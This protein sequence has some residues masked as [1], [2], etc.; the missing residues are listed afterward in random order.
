MNKKSVLRKGIEYAIY[1]S[2]LVALYFVLS[3]I[4]AFLLI[5]PDDIG[6]E[7]IMSGVTTGEPSPYCWFIRYPL[8]YVIS[9]LYKLVGSVEWYE[10]FLMGCHVLCYYLVLCRAI[11]LDRKDKVKYVTIALG[12]V[13]V[14]FGEHII[15]LEWSITAG[16]MGAVAVYRY[17][18]IPLDIKK[19][20]ATFEYFICLCLLVVGFSLRHNVIYMYMPLAFLCW[21]KRMYDIKNTVS[22]NK[23][24]RKHMGLNLAFIVTAICCIVV[25]MFIHSK[26]YSTKEWETYREYT[27]DRSILVDYYGYPAYDEYE[28]LYE[29]AG[30][31]KEMYYIMTRD[32]NYF[33]A[34]DNVDKIQLD[35]IADVARDNNKDKTFYENLEFTYCKVERLFSNTRFWF[36]GIMLILSL[37]VLIVKID[38]NKKV[39]MMYFVGTMAWFLIMLIY[40]AHEGRLPI[41]I[42]S[43]LVYGFCAIV[44]GEIYKSVIDKGMEEDNVI[45]EN[46][47]NTSKVQHISFGILFVGLIVTN[48]FD[49]YL[50][51]VGDRNDAISKNQVLEYC[52]QHP[53][54]LFLRDFESFSQYGN[55]FCDSIDSVNYLSTGGW[56]YNSPVFF[57][58]IEENGVSS[59]VTAIKD[60][61]KICYIA[62]ADRYEHLSE[63][64]NAYFESINEPIVAHVVDIF[65][66]QN[67]RVVV[68]QFSEE[69]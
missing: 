60:G 56:T 13:L 7:N 11:R 47:W 14:L 25:V 18:T 52:V 9:C 69:K 66:I 46:L 62:S 29:Q 37:L 67:D 48:M 36:L 39:Q 5:S 65:E 49:I 41:R 10:L 31:T 20:Q 53:D 38:S 55:L 27:K 50:S 28:E 42:G 51:N 43:S 8:S 17:T 22:D 44:F 68:F 24:I 64:L 61:K 30:I 59:I 34:F 35:V 2:V 3:K 26:A 32:Y 45:H 21:L 23:E 33:L 58:A 63:G 1:A 54:Y 19:R 40:V 6:Y 57:D 12:I 4:Y 15:N 16:I